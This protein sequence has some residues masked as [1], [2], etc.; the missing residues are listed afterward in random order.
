MPLFQKAPATPEEVARSRP[1]DIPPDQVAELD[2]EAWY[3]R[4][5]RGDDVP[6]LTVRAVLMG[7]GLG[8]VRASTNLY[9]GL[10]S[11]WGSGVAITACIVSFTVWNALLKLGLARTPMS[12]LENNC[13]QSTASAAGYSTGNTMVS[14]IPALL[15]L[16][17]TPELTGG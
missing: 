16:S 1:L 2:E 3:A 6:Q 12:I 4:V 11:G 5:Y 14:A 10:K 13:M 9:M 7:S 15:L 17:V 8:V